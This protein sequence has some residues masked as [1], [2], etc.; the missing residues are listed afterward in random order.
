MG[1]VQ[2]RNG[3]LNLLV[4]A[5]LV[6]DENSESAITQDLPHSCKYFNSSEVYD[7]CKYDDSNIIGVRI[8]NK[9]KKINVKTTFVNKS[10]GNNTVDIRNVNKVHSV[11][12]KNV[13]ADDCNNSNDYEKQ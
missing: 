12:V 5:R 10:D 3:I 6:V 8:V 2:R 13:P 1:V 4:L 7:S 11:N 9:E